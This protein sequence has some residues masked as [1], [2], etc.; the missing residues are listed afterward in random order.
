MKNKQENLE[1]ESLNKYD[2]KEAYQTLV[3]WVKSVPNAIKEIEENGSKEELIRYKK[4]IKM[5]V[6]KLK[7]IKNNFSEGNN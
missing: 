5:V 4:Q 3:N 1:S 7:E 2:G 6:E